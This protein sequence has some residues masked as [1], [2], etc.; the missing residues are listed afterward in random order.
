MAE[1]EELMEGAGFD[2]PPPPEVFD[3]EV[4]LSGEDEPVK[5]PRSKATYDDDE[6]VLT[7]ETGTYTAFRWDGVRY[8][9]GKAV[10]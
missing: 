4:Y 9:T 7:A 2:P 3:F 6:L 1:F 8:Y 5:V 10:R